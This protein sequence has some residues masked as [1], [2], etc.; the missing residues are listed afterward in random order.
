MSKTKKLEKTIPRGRIVVIKGKPYWFVT[1]SQERQLMS[2]AINDLLTSGYDPH[3]VIAITKGGNFGMD[4]ADDVLNVPYACIASKHYKK[5]KKGQLAKQVNKR[6]KLAEHFS[7]VSNLL[8]LLEV[9]KRVRLLIVDDLTDWGDTYV[10]LEFK[11]RQQFGHR[12]E[13]RTLCLWKKDRSTFRADFVGKVIHRH[14][15]T[16]KYPW[17]ITTE[18]QLFANAVK[19]VDQGLL[20]RYNRRRKKHQIIM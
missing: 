5:G 14:R 10:K 7:T 16:G 15:A 18:D 19:G 2:R 20:R 1:E 9:G 8:K 12:F 11:L 13:M 3:A 4:L 17:I 6:V